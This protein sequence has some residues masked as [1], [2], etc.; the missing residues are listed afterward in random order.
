MPFA[1]MRDHT[2]RSRKSAAA[3]GSARSSGCTA[4]GA[5]WMPVATPRRQRHLVG[6]DDRVRQPADAR[7][8]GHGAVAQRA[9]LRQAARLEARRHEQRVAPAWIRCASASS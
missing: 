1:W 2:R 7:D 9:E 3:R 6:I 4:D 8:D 5:N